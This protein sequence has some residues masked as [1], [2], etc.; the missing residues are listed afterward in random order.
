[1]LISNITIVS[2]NYS[3][4][5][6]ILFPT[7]FFLMKLGDCNWIRNHN[8]LVRKRT[9]NHLPKLAKWL[10]C[11]VSTYLYDEFDCMSYQ[12]NAVYRKVLTTQH[13]HLASLAKWLNLRLRTKWLWVQVQLQS[14]RLV[15]APVSSNESLDIQAALEC[16]FILQRV[17]DMIRTCI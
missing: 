2:Q 9:L 5:N 8:H 16:G 12:S 17:R 15:F 11:V 13:N 1:M 7:L 14:L 6:M 3:L 10:S 4:N